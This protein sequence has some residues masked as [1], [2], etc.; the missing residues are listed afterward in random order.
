MQRYVIPVTGILGVLIK[1]NGV[2]SW[3]VVDETQLPKWMKQS[4]K[5]ELIILKS[6]K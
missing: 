5:L 4:W 6:K 2:V 3:S 1:A